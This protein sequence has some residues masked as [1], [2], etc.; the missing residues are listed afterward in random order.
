MFQVAFLHVQLTVKGEMHT[1][2]NLRESGI[3]WCHGGSY[4]GDWHML[5]LACLLVGHMLACLLGE[6]LMAC[7]LSQI[8]GT[9]SPCYAQA[10]PKLY[11]NHSTSTWKLQQ[12]TL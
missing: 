8:E 2:P 4:V 11:Q 3:R 5:Q 7:W 1:S 6:L 9:W 12:H 10:H